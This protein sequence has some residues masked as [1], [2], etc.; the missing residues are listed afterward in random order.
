MTADNRLPGLV[1]RWEALRAAGRPVSVEELCGDCP[2]LVPALRERLGGLHATDAVSGTIHDRATRAPGEDPGVTRAL[3]GGPPGPAA[4]RPSIPGYQIFGELGRGGMG[5]VY[6]ARQLG[7]NRLVALKMILGGAH[8]GP[9]QLARFRQEVETVGGLR[10]PN[11]VPVYEV[12]ERDGQPYYSMELVEGRSLEALIG[13]RPQPPRRAAELLEALARAMSAVHQRDIVH[14]DLK[15]ANVLFTEDGVPKIT[16]FGLAKR[17]DAGPG[18]TVSGNVLGTPSYMAPEQAAGRAKDVGPATDVY[19]LGAVLYEM[20]TGRPP[21]QGERPWD[22]IRAVTSVEPVPPRRLQPTVPRDLETICLKCLEKEPRKRYATA[23][24]LADDLRR[25]LAGESVRACPV[26]PGGRLL[27]W[28]RRRPAAAAL[29][30]VSGLAGL[31]FVAGVVVHQVQLGE[32]LRRADASAEESRRR[33]VRLH[34]TQGARSLDAGDWLG[35]LPWFAEALRLDE[36]HPGREQMHRVRLGC[37]L[38]QS[39]RL[40]RLWFHEGPVCQARFNPEGRLVLTVSEDRTARLWDADTGAP[41]C[42]PLEHEAVVLCG[43]FGPRGRSV[44]TGAKDGTA[45]VW[46]AEGGRPATPPLR[47]GGPVVAVCFSPDGRRLLTASE[48]GTARVWDAATGEPVV[49][50]LRHGGP[51]R[52]ATWAPGGACLLTASDDRTAQ[53]WDARTGGPVGAPLRHAGAVTWAAFAPDGRRVATA[54]ADG[55]A[56]VWDASAGRQVVGPLKHQAAVLRVSFSPDGRRLLTAGEDHAAR[57][58]EARTGE[59]LAPALRERGGVG[60]AAFSPDGRRV[61]TAGDDN[62][63]RVWDAATGELL[64]ALLRHNGTV[65]DARFGPRGPLLLTASADGTARLWD[66][67]AGRDAPPGGPGEDPG[68]ALPAGPGRWWSADRRWVVTAEAGNGARVRQA[69]TGRPR[70]PLLEHGSKVIHAGFSPDG[71]RVI[72]ASD[73]NTARVWDAATGELLAPPLVHDATVTYAA[74]SPDGRMAVTLGTERRARVWE[75]ATG[76]PLTPPL[77]FDGPARR[78]YFAADG[79]RVI[80]VGVGRAVASWDLRRDDRPVDDLLWE[81]QVLAGS[82]ID[83]SR[84]L[85]PLAGGALRDAWRQVGRRQAGGPDRGSP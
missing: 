37:V 54:C 63:A 34:V 81:A 51:V 9:E 44:A 36:G 74:F 15:P 62:T 80:V 73:D 24:E 79:S 61:L 22:T 2:D 71:R 26:G 6:K 5:V 69:D 48:D 60:A 42:P 68:E 70:G 39:P 7:F 12:G 4:G 29:L 66:V 14:R 41:A 50:P 55:G 10:H 11:L 13:G 52:C 16:D 77:Q 82:R 38:R 3:A 64:T 8:A 23:Q 17:L 49:A 21:F 85:L 46:G 35:A 40:L 32:A 59:L 57:V 75:A 72:T 84:G 83:P 43:A 1:A 25:F 65:R 67:T 18:P 28:A 20:L 53:L 58:W 27:K 76:E 33:L 45:R 31:G 47:H 56:R 30:A 19:A 78:A